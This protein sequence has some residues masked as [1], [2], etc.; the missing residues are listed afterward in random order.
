M[1]D[2]SS[3]GDRMLSALETVA[4]CGPVSAADVARRNGINR[5]VAHRLLTTLHRRSY[6]RRVQGGYV[7]G[8]AIMRLSQSVEPELVGAITPEVAALAEETGE[9]VVAHVI[10]GSDAVVIAQAI[11]TRHLVRVQHEEGS[12]HPLAAGASGRALLAFQ[13][14]ERIEAVARTVGDAA[15]LHRRL[16]GVR[17]LGYAVSHDELQAGAH[18]LAAPVRD[19]Q[20]VARASVALVVPT[21]RA[22]V[23]NECLDL[24]LATAG[25]IE[26][27][28]F[29]DLAGVDQDERLRA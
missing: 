21:G 8:P 1:T 18:G 13:P 17:A 29:G 20:G 23:L 6:V 25:R 14:P 16:E 9:T 2:I 7:V 12:R 10:D 24:I 28:L 22:A 3:T 11:G 19:R 27:R 5:T 26:R 15:G 4:A